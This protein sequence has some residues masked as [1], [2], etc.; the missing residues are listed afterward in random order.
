LKEFLSF[1]L[2]A[3]ESYAFI[4]S[5]TDEAAMRDELHTLER[6]TERPASFP[7]RKGLQPEDILGMY[8]L[9]TGRLDEEQRGE[10]WHVIRIEEAHRDY[11]T[12]KLSCI[13]GRRVWVNDNGS[14]VRQS[15]A[16]KIIAYCPPSFMANPHSAKV[17]AEMANEQ[18]RYIYA[19]GF[20]IE[21]D[22]Y[23][24]WRAEQ[25]ARLQQILRGE[26]C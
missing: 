21:A 8:A 17:R 10:R 25:D 23:P 7:A 26:A 6:T 9:T 12:G 18:Y 16:V 14:I 5:S 4:A 13:L 19:A 24:A 1:R 15:D 22:A 20:K 2:Q 11:L 3:N